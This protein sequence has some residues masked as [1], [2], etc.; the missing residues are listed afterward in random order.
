MARL[1]D[2]WADNGTESHS[3]TVITTEPNGIVGNLHD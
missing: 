2:T 3:F 1:W